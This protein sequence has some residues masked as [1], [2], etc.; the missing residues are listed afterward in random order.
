MKVKN[1]AF[2]GFAAAILAMGAANAAAVPQIAS[3]S[4][5][6]SKIDSD[7]QTLRETIENNYTTTEELTDIIVNNITNEL[8]NDDGALKE[9]LEGKANTSDVETLESTVGDLESAMADK[10]DKIQNVGD[11]AGN[12]ATVDANGQYQ[13]SDVN[14]T[15]LVTNETV[16][17][18]ITEVLEGN[19]TV[20]EI[21]TTIVGDGDIV[22]EAIDQSVTSGTLKTE[23]DKKANVEDVYTKEQTNQLFDGTVPMPEGECATESNRCVVSYDAVTKKM[24]WLDVTAPLGE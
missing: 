24:V 10:A 3:K 13:V 18:K 11:K 19:D 23:L 21:I 20:K 6:D 12:I 4:Y 15:D 17:T 8:T 5:V 7:V 9:A 1:I 14:A 16:T 2:S 22:K